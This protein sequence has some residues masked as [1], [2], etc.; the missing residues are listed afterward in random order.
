MHALQSGLESIASTFRT[1]DVVNLCKKYLSAPWKNPLTNHCSTSSAAAQS[2]KLLISVN[3]LLDGCGVALQNLNAILQGIE[4][5]WRVR[6]LPRKP[7]KALKINLASADIDS[8][9]HQLRSYSSAMQMTLHM[10]GM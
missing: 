8:I 10:V 5:P 9:R 3:P 2:T 6:V 7:T 1:D 4:K